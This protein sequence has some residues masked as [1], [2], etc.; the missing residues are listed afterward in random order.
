L[1]PIVPMVEILSVTLKNFKAHSD[2]AFAFQPGTNAI[3]GENGAGKTSILE[4]IAWVLFD[5][6]GDYKT[7]D[8]IR[9]GAT[10]GQAT[11]QFISSRDQ[12]T[13]EVQRSTRSGYTLYDP[14]LNEKLNISRIK[15]EVQPW[16]REHLGVSPGTDLS[17]LFAST[18]GVPQGMFTADFQL[19]PEKR[20]A[21]FDKVLKVEEY[22]KTWK[23]F[24]SLEKYA[25]AQSE[26]IDRE[27]GHYDEQLQ[28]SAAVTQQHQLLT[29]EIAQV[30]TDLTQWQEKLTALQAEQTRISA[31]ATKLQQLINQVTEATAQVKTQEKLLNNLYKQLEQAQQA[32]EIC[33]ARREAYQAVLQAEEAL[34][35]LEEKRSQQQSVFEQRQ[36]LIQQDSDRT[37]QLTGLNTQLERCR[38]AETELERIQ[39]QIERQTE[40]EK[41][42]QEIQEQLQNLQS[43]RQTMTRDQKRLVQLNERQTQIQQSIQKLESLKATIDEIPELEAQQ[44]RY[45]Q[46][47]SRI[48]AATQ[49]EADLRQILT[50]AETRDK[51]HT[52]QLKTA[53]TVLKELQM[54]VPD[55]KPAITTVLETLTQGGKLQGQL[56]SDLQGILDDLGEQVLADRLQTL[57]QQNQTE[58]RNLRQ[59]QAQYLTIADKQ[60]EQEQLAAEIK[61]VEA[62]IAESQKQLAAEPELSQQAAKLQGQLQ[63]LDDPRGR[64]RFLAKEV[65]QKA[66]IA[67][68]QEQLKSA[69]AETQQTIVTLEKQLETF[70]DLTEQITTQ[71]QI[72]DQHRPDYVTYLEH[73]KA[74]NSFKKMKDNYN[75]EYAK[76]NT[77]KEELDKLQAEQQ[78]LAATIDPEQVKAMQTAFQEANTQTITLKA[79]LPEKVK[80]L[81]TFAQQLAKLQEIQA[82][83]DAAQAKLKQ[84]QKVDRFIK[85]ARKA[86]K[87]AGPRITELYLQTISREADKLFRELLNRPNVALE[88]TRDYEIVVREAANVRRFINLSG[89]EQ[90]CAALAVRLALLKV[91]A[92][93]NIAFFDEPTTNMDRPRRLQLAEA[94]ANIRTFRQLFVISHDD[95]FEQ[96]TENVILVTRDMAD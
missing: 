63:E 28:E 39:P 73:Q 50:Q 70:A 41:Q 93:I 12:R 19:S 23:D 27:I 55:R 33:T 36:K 31:Q 2:R 8:F 34:Q 24:N 44:Q 85:F 15:E 21:V 74:A 4:A 48:A 14:Q 49:F 88:W 77:S 65:Q 17:E 3:S 76:F 61:E 57:I 11:V 90:M 71:Q 26:A 84:Q 66:K 59:T 9:N 45:Q 40:L 43:W 67:Q 81:E 38:V 64:S 37:N 32:V 78:E 46:Q 54:V 68:Q 58:L 16:L 25:K 83:R 62:H 29:Q 52:K 87:E 10:A 56:V 60:K 13:Y 82:K 18:I 96:V 30:Q 22:Q 47:L 95:T 6:K 7:E 86:Y 42:Q 80:R 75:E 1:P 35:E 91:L 20:K 94:I 69:M 53:T 72:R 89:G 79:Q 51:L 92:D 5:H